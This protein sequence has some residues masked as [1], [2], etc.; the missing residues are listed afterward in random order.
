MEIIHSC[1]K[2]LRHPCATTIGAC[3]RTIF[4]TELARPCAK[5][6]SWD[7]VHFCLR[8]AGTKL[9]SDLGFLASQILGS[10]GCFSASR[11]LGLSGGFLTSRLQSMQF[12]FCQ[13]C[14]PWMPPVSVWPWARVPSV[15]RHGSQSV[16]WFCLVSR[17][18]RA[19]YIHSFLFQFSTWFR[20]CAKLARTWACAKLVKSLR[21][22][23]TIQF[24]KE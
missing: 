16:Q 3:A 8:D 21:A 10:L 9:I 18:E 5:M 20:A 24:F 19:L 17:S 6:N 7:L 12:L 11:L 15:Q 1:A 4:Q 2:S 23:D 13:Q 14:S 22:R